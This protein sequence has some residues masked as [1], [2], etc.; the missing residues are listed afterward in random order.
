LLFS[1]LNIL[2]NNFL[3]VNRAL[4]AKESIVTTEK[5]VDCCEHGK[6]QATFVCNHVVESLHD[7]TPRGFWWANDPDNPRPDAWCSEC[8]KRLKANDGEWN[9]EI[10]TLAN[11]RLLCGVCYDNAKSLNFPSQKKWWKFW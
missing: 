4:Y 9:E 10:E 3:P 8:E 11:I 5:Y 1:F 2:A 6:Q 7:E